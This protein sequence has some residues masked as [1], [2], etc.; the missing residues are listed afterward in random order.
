MMKDICINLQNVT[1]Y[2]IIHNSLPLPRVFIA[3]GGT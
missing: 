3:G 2:C 1:Y